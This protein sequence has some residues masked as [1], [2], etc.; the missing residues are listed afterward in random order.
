M[1]TVSLETIKPSRAI[2]DTLQSAQMIKFLAVLDYMYQQQYDEIMKLK[3]VIDVDGCP[4]ELLPYHA[5]EMG[6][7]LPDFATSLAKRAL[8]RNA[9]TI[10]NRRF[11]E[12]GFEFY[13]NTTFTG[14]GITVDVVADMNY[15]G[16]LFYGQMQDCAYP[17][18]DDMKTAGGVNDICKYYITNDWFARSFT[19]T[20][21]GQGVGSLT[22]QIRDFCEEVGEWFV[23][24]G[25]SGSITLN[26]VFVENP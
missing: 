16:I 7:I 26:F 11:T 8:L 13:L 14:L 25:D 2:P 22:Q 20:I 18:W 24:M 1:N 9:L 5:K 4:E 17:N 3:S 6:L 10:H 12:A 21:T 15:G 23:P 19:L